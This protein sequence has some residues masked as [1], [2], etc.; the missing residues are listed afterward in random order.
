MGKSVDVSGIP[1]GIV[2]V[3]GYHYDHQTI[4]TTALY[5]GNIAYRHFTFNLHPGRCLRCAQKTIFII[6]FIISFK[7]AL[8]YCILLCK[9]MLNETYKF[10]VPVFQGWAEHGILTA[11]DGLGYVSINSNSS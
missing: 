1:T 10:Q 9:W 5:L 7:E 8:Y 2:R 6:N 11:S 4:T 3:E